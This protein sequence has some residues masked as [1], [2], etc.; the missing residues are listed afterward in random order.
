MPQ[1]LKN[2]PTVQETQIRSLGWEDPL[3]RAWQPIPVFLPGKSYGQRSRVGYGPWSC[4]GTKP[5]PNQHLVRIHCETWPQTHILP[6]TWEFESLAKLAC[7]GQDFPL[8]PLPTIGGSVVKP[9]DHASS[10]SGPSFPDWLSDSFGL[11]L[12]HFSPCGW[13]SSTVFLDSQ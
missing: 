3:G 7:F 5:P 6:V 4:K 12:T 9:M 13:V 11:G 10:C 2:S 8:F 1:S